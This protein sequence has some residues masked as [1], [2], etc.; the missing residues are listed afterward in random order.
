MG[1]KQRYVH[2]LRR[3]VAVPGWQTLTLTEAASSIRHRVEER[4]FAY[5][6]NGA[7]GIGFRT[8]VGKLHGIWGRLALTLAYVMAPRAQLQEV[9]ERAAALAER[10]VFDYL[11]PNMARFHQA[12]SSER[13][14]ETTRA[15]AAFVLRQ[16]TVRLTPRAIQGHVAA[17]HRA[18]ADQVRD[19]VSPLITMGWLTPLANEDERRASG[20]E[21]NQDVYAQFAERA[22]KARADAVIAR[23]L[24]L[25]QFGR[26]D[27]G[28]DDINGENPTAY[29]AYCAREVHTQNHK[30][31]SL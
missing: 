25:D 13:D 26:A 12:L 29:D 18:K 10:L 1:V 6:Q 5:R 4:L 2:L 9:D 24:L 8:A 15:I 16:H 11:V 27:T 20:W 23:Q 7:L 21:V 28:D 19:A 14:V 3:L 17:L 22:V 30:K 31:M